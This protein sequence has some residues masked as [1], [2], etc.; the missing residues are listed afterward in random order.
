VLEP[1]QRTAFEQLMA[2]RRQRLQRW[3]GH[4]RQSDSPQD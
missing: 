4:L 3:R 2:E 1:E